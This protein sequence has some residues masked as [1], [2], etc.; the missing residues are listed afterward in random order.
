[1]NGE[2]KK[3]LTVIMIVLSLVGIVGCTDSKETQQEPKIEEIQGHEEVDEMIRQNIYDMLSD[4]NNKKPY[5]LT[6]AIIDKESIEVITTESTGY[7]NFTIKMNFKREFSTG[8]SN[9][10]FVYRLKRLKGKGL[11]EMNFIKDIF[12]DYVG[13]ETYI[14]DDSTCLVS[15]TSE[16]YIENLK[17]T[18]YLDGQEFKITDKALR[19]ERN[20]KRSFFKKIGYDDDYVRSLIN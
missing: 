20:I 15:S 17:D 16:K 12:I 5:K 14:L 2:F 4:T 13:Y 3:L 18:L 7:Y 11:E 6:D 19:K 1:M 10:I 8:T 9:G